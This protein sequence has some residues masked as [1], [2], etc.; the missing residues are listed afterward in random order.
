MKRSGIKKKL[1]KNLIIL[2]CQWQ[3]EAQSKILESK[4]VYFGIPP[5]PTFPTNA[6]KGT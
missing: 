5:N 2:H 3:E 6:L 4:T 1:I